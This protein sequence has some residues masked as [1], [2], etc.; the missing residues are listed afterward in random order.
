MPFEIIRNDITKMKVDA[1][2]NAANRLLM[3]GGGVDGMIHRAAGPELLEECRTLNGCETGQA[4]ITG[5]Y[6]LP[7]RYVIHTV[8][9][10]WHGGTQNERALLASC[11]RNSLKLAVEHGC[12]TV[13]FPMIS[14]GAYGYPKDQ[15]MT[16]AV[17]TIGEFLLTHDLMVYLVVF[18]RE[19]FITGTKLFRDVREYIDDTYS[20]RRLPPV[21]EKL[22]ERL[23][24]R[25]ESAAQEMDHALMEEISSE[26]GEP[27]KI[28]SGRGE[29]EEKFSKI[30]EPEMS[31]FTRPAP[32]SKAQERPKASFSPRKSFQELVGLN[33]RI[34]S[35]DLKELLRK[36][37][38]GFSEALLR[39]ID[40]KGMTDTECYKKANVDR[41]LFSKIRSNPAY[42]PSKPTA[43]AFAIALEL[44]L[45]E[46]ETL[47][48]RAGY[49]LT[50]SSRFDIVMEY[51]I[52]RR[53]FNIQDINMVLFELDLPLL[54]SGAA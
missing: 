27:K 20:E 1:I 3:G 9:P 48:R 43:L 10:I 32:K 38:E 29:P 4:K 51:F 22:R 40:E 26:K 14:A 23:W 2:V 13:A 54:G 28:S 47:I 25:N 35:P 41:K 45:P 11:Y 6:Q 34:P 36:T 37:D 7:A 53:H 52:Q 17:E 5:G 39:L 18:G 16:V 49:A 31:A 24:H 46:T 19:E 21:R 15:A 50:K 30:S 42:R 12:E 33:E 44:T 8:G